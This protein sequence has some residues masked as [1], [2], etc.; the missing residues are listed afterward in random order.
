[1][2]AVCVAL[3]SCRD[4]QPSQTSSVIQGFQLDG[5]VTSANGIPLDSVSVR[6]YYDFHDFGND[7]V[8]TQ[9]VVV[10]DSTRIVD[11]SVYTPKLVFIRQLFFNY[12][13]T[14]PVP[15]FTWDQRDQHGA[16]VPSG[17]Y[18]IRYAIDTAVV[19]YSVVVIDGRITA[20]TDRLGHF[21]IPGEHLPVGTVFDAYTPENVYDATV[22][23]GSDVGLIL[24]KAGLQ[25]EYPYVQLKK[26]QITTA[27]FTLG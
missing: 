18:W 22:R 5:T 14:G 11:V 24:F 8:D 17:E 19:K 2:C 25:V 26:N 4:V 13:R 12:R 15:R 16:L 1:M 6:L 21:V 27:L 23:V 3:A 7:P 20:L 10:T 9:Q